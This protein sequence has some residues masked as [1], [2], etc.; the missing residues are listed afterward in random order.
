MQSRNG[1]VFI[2]TLG[3]GDVNLAESGSGGA[4]SVTPESLETSNSELSEELT[5]MI[6]AQ[7]AYQAS[8]KVITTADELL[9]ELNRLT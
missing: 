4:G 8:A 2:Q 1:N 6:V 9:D 7:R 3:S 5:D